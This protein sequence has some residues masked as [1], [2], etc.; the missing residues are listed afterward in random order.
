MATINLSWIDSSIIILY[1]I[2]LLF[3]GYIVKKK[4]KGVNDYFLAGRRLTLPIF[5]ATLVSTWYGGLLGVGELSFNYGLVNWLTQ[6]IFWYLSYLIFAFFL[7]SKVRKSK[8]YTIP[9]Q[10][11][12]FYDKKS[13]VLGAI[14]NFIMVTPAPYIMSLGIIFG[15]LFGW[16]SWLGIIV[17][18]IVAVFYTLRGGFVGVIY[19]DFLQFI[20]MCTGVALIIPFAI[21]KYGGMNF[22]ISNLPV[23]HL[24]FTGTWTTQMILVWGFIAFWTL[25]DPGFYQRCYA[26]KDSKIPKKGILIAIVFWIMFD[27]CTTFTG[28]YARAAMP[29]LDPLTS[30]PIFAAS[31]L[32]VFLKGL[33]FTG[34]LATIMST[35]DSFTFL[36]A[37]NIGHDIYKKI[38]NKKANDEKVIK[39]TKIGVVITAGFGLILALFFK[40]LVFMWYTIGTVGISVMLVP[41]LG[42]FFYKGRKSSLAAFVSMILAATTSITWLVIGWINMYE[43]WPTYWFNI[44]PLYP[45]LIISLL[46]YIIITIFDKNKRLTIETA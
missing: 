32:P 9:D 30:Y 1:F 40:S 4:I 12:R 34:V 14:F 5:I 24:T 29:G 36:G 46:A 7:A 28:L 19:T 37:M 13:R 44:E 33:F 21:S 39:V 25:V 26:A 42:G 2:M 10:L 43:G 23:G 41:V 35:I 22:L 8:M 20:L 6:G 15:L 11:E 27:A 18:T 45:G 17:G 31:V 16:P 38:I 3:I